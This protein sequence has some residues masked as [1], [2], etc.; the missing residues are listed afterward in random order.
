MSR[1]TH[2]SLAAVPLPE[3]V[4]VEEEEEDEDEDEEDEEEDDDDD[5]EDEDRILTGGAQHQQTHTASN[6]SLT[7]KSRYSM[8]SIPPAKKNTLQCASNTCARAR[9][10]CSSTPSHRA[11]RLRKSSHSSN[12]FYASRTRTTSP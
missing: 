1:R 5:D 6:A 2:P 8:S 10:S 11:N 7:T 12:R 4:E 3:E 9:D